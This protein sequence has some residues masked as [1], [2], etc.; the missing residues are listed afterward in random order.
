MLSYA[1][2]RLSLFEYIEQL[3]QGEV[4]K[5][6]TG[7]ERMAQYEVVLRPKPKKKTE[8]PESGED[9]GPMT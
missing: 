3:V 9:V 5:M 6:I 8:S 7:E 4:K 1:L 2:K